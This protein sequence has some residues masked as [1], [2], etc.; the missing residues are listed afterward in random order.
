MSVY[1]VACVTGGIGK[2]NFSCPIPNFSH[3]LDFTSIGTN[4]DK[5]LREQ[6]IRTALGNAI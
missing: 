4:V 3:K 6:L 5:Q 2:M 1:A